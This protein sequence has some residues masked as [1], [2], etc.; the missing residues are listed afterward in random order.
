MLYIDRSFNRSEFIKISSP[1]AST[2]RID[3]CSVTGYMDVNAWV[4][5]SVSSSSVHHCNIRRPSRVRDTRT[6]NERV[7]V[8]ISALWM[9]SVIWKDRLT[10]CRL[11]DVGGEGRQGCDDSWTS[12][13]PIEISNVVSESTIVFPGEV[14]VT[15]SG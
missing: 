12:S 3:P 13:G 1:S 6:I 9:V 7:Q 15:G 4:T 11:I 8:K 5:S 10:K 14:L 2:E